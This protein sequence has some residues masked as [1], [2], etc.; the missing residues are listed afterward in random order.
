MEEGKRRKQVRM[1]NEPYREDDDR[2]LE[3]GEDVVEEWGKCG[4]DVL[5]ENRG[6]DACLPREEVMDREAHQARRRDFRSIEVW[7]LDLALD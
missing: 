4:K 2:G 1:N 7:F 5:V 6:S 3:R